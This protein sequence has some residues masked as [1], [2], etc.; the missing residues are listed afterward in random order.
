MTPWARFSG[1]IIAMLAMIS[2]ISCRGNQEN[3][4]A[5][6]EGDRPL[7]FQRVTQSYH[8]DIQW[9]G[10]RVAA[11]GVNRGSKA[12]LDS[13]LVWIQTSATDMI[14]PVSTVGLHADAATVRK[15][16]GIPVDSL[17]NETKYT[18]WIAEK[19]VFDGALNSTLRTPFSF[20]DTS[21]TINVLFTSPM[22]WGE[23]DPSDPFEERPL[24][25]FS[26]VRDEK[27][28]GDRFIVSWTPDT[29]A[30]RRIGIRKGSYPAFT[31]LVWHVFLPDSVP[32]KIRPPICVPTPPSGAGVAV[33]WPSEG[34]EKGTVY[35]LWMV[36]TGW[37]SMPPDWGSFAKGYSGMTFKPIPQ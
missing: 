11:V 34:F 13:T 30:F 33:D 1:S 29:V 15:Y 19:A 36:R 37:K 35:F 16:R 25:T 2:M 22:Q 14:G 8:P 9:L 7:S 18:F 26:I 12:A 27:L 31:D 23:R 24:V 20:R 21:F 17:E 6:Y 28:T 4:L 3:P 32:D 5:A 10:G